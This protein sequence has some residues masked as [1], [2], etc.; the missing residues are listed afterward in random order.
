M[1]AW[2]LIIRL[3]YGH[4]GDGN[5]AVAIAVTVPE[6]IPTNYIAL[7]IIVRSFES[8]ENNSPWQDLMVD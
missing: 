2:P 6:L 5:A 3:N 1:W 8:L 7:N 4:P